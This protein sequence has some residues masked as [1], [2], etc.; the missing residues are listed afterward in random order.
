M[1]IQGAYARLLEQEVAAFAI[2]PYERLEHSA[3]NRCVQFSFHPLGDLMFSLST[4][5]AVVPNHGLECY[6]GA[7]SADHQVLPIE[8]EDGD[9]LGA[10]PRAAPPE[11]AP[12][13]AGRHTLSVSRWVPP[14]WLLSISERLP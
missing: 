11:G 6:P 3:K 9:A 14:L 10:F 2:H 8:L 5:T 7:T 4:Q 1:G 12:R 13:S